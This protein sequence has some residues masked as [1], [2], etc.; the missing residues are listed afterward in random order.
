MG[1]VQGSIA[2]IEPP[3]S[4]ELSTGIRLH[5]A[6]RVLQ[7]VL[8]R[9]VSMPVRYIGSYDLSHDETLTDFR[10]TANVSL[11]RLVRDSPVGHERIHELLYSYMEEEDPYT[12]DVKAEEAVF[13]IT[14]FFVLDAVNTIDHAVSIHRASSTGVRDEREEETLGLVELVGLSLK[15]LGISADSPA[16]TSLWPN[17]VWG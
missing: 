16:R 15:V 17:T 14:V 3:M 8:G 9:D 2:K 5:S 12:N 6:R 11:R 1:R 4:D 13:A 7:Q 10:A